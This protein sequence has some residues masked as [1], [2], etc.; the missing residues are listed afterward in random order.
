MPGALRLV[1]TAVVRRETLERTDGN[2]LE[3]LAQQTGL[4]TES[5]ML[6]HAAANAGKGTLLEN[7][8]ERARAIRLDQAVYKTANVD[9][10]RAGANTFRVG[11]METAQGLFESL[12]G[13][14]A[15]I[16]FIAALNAV[17]S[18]E[19]HFALAWCF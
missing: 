2:G 12:I 7:A 10:K 15:A 8:F 9:V 5:L 6:A 14:E 18:R 3:F 16:D 17:F 4:L 19:Q 13:G 11:A 1:L